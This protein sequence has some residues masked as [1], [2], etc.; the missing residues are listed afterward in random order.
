MARLTFIIGMAAWTAAV[1]GREI[2]VAK[3]GGEFSL[4]QD[5]LD[6]AAPGDVV[7]VRAGTY[8]ERLTVPRGGD[9]TNGPI[10]LR[11]WPGE[12]AILRVN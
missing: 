3:S 4:I 9:T 5:G 2:V 11:A 6:A 1:L 7:S 8:Y 10:V 12:S